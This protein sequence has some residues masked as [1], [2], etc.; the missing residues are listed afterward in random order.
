MGGLILL[1]ALC[2]VMA[3]AS[4]LAGALPLSMTLTQSQMRLISSIGI[5]ILVGT[6][7]IV[8]IPEGIEAAAAPAEASRIHKTRSLLRRSPWTFGIE[9]HDII[10]TFPAIRTAA[11]GGRMRN[12]EADG[13]L[14]RIEMRQSRTSITRREDDEG[15]DGT[16]TVAPP[17]TGGSHAQHFEIP[18]LEIGFSM[19]LGFVLMFLIDRIPRHATESFRPAPET[20]HMSLDNLGG[21][22][23]S[24][25]EEADGFLGS[26][27]PTPAVREVLPPR[28][29]W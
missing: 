19:I 7:L 25:D 29:A 27:T 16:P 4:F 10:E 17:A 24:I 21:D 13:T 14:P 28:S 11:D 6:S 9:T 1:V 12:G 3:L 22:T 26:L 23:S 5:G 15:L 2:V 8:I 20:R 18:T